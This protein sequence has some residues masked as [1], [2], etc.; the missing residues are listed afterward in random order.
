MAPFHELQTQTQLLDG[1][2]AEFAKLYS[3][4]CS[5]ID[6]C[7]SELFYTQSHG[8]GGVSL[9]SVGESVLR[10]AATVEQICGGITSNL[11][12]DP[13][14]WTLPET[15]TTRER[16]LEYLDE[17]ETTRKRAFG[18]VLSDSDLLRMIPMPSGKV[19][20]LASLLFETLARACQLQ[21]RASL[22]AEILSAQNTAGFII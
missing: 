15:L 16:I 20:T 14:E 17:V 11:W 5:L 10:S 12:D 4:W 3:H 21:G 1:L 7:P 8:A 2:S 22:T 9:P 6:A 19:Q 13:F 18:S